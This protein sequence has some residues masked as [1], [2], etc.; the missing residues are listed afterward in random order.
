MIKAVFLDVDNTL[1][2]P[3]THVIPE[4]A[5]KAIQAARQNGVLVF[6]ATG[7]NTLNNLELNT[8]SGLELDGYVGLSGSICHFRG[9][10]PFYEMTLDA[11][12]AEIVFALQREMKFAMLVVAAHNMFITEINDRVREF[13]KLWDIGLPPLLPEGFEPKPLYLLGPYADREAESRITARLRKTVSARWNEW[14][15]DLIPAE[16]GKHV[17]MRIMLEHFGLSPEDA[18]AV[19]DA[20][21]DITM[22]EFAGVG[23]AMDHALEMVKKSADFVAPVEEPIRRV[24]EKYRII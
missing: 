8:I 24:F 16:S 22:L 5:V 6:A 21:N 14:G 2:D 7:R 1:T 20:E 3:R 12:D 9:E 11:D 18:L 19:G 4:S 23:V 10:K 17:G 13:S 15:F